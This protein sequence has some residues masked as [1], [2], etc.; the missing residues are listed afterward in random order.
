M[1]EGPAQCRVSI[2][3]VDFNL[4]DAESCHHCAKVR[5]KWRDVTPNPLPNVPKFLEP[6][7][8]SAGL[9]GHF[10]TYLESIDACH[11]PDSEGISLAKGGKRV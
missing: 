3:S 5:Q 8:G 11:D 1:I 10:P 4:C 7:E 2:N 9:E 6:V